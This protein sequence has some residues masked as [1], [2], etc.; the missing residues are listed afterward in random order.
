[1]SIIHYYSLCWNEEIILPFTLDYYSKFCQKI[2]IYDNES[3]DNSH[4]IIKS[5]ENSEIRTYSS[6][7]E[8]R[9]DIYV[10]IKNNVWKES[11]GKADWVIVCDTD[12]ILYHPQ[13]VEKLDELKLKGITIIKPYGYDM[14]SETMPHKS[15]LEIKDGLKDNRH[16]GKCVI[17]NPNLIDEIN[18]KPGCHKC[19]PKGKIKL[20]HHDD[21]KLLHYK[22]L[23]LEYL[24]DRHDS[25]RKRLSKQN[26]E[27]KQ[28][29]QY[30]IEK[31]KLSLIF[32][33]NLKKARKVID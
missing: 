24:L 30:L 21:I 2:I 12:E 26:I 10:E 22:H 6:N 5:Y 4:S 11:R 20:Y 33:Q 29:K 13:I 18:F 7:C 17:F 14:Y 15:I 25:F 31:Q 27:N 19:K 1:M 32:S 8:I 23:N 9:D 3:D 16:F 28:G